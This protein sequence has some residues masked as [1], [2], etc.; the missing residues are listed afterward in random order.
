MSDKTATWRS[1]VA[2]WRASGQTAAVYAVEQG[3]SVHALRSWSSRFRRAD[4]TPVAGPTI[5]LARVV[6]SAAM[7]TP[8]RSAGGIIIELR[9]VRARIAI[10]GRVDREALAAVVAVL[11]EDAR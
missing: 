1:R 11:R 2:A 6:K 5:R 7:D 9:D 10:E 3:L 4:Q 8:V